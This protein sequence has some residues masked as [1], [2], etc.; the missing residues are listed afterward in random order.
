MPPEKA[1]HVTQTQETKAKA[2]VP[3]VLRQLQQPLGNLSVLSIELELIAIAILTKTSYPTRQTDTQA[4]LL[5]R[6]PSHLES[7]RWHYGFLQ[8]PQRTHLP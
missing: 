8:E 3:L 7:A 1:L 5:D 6:P 4:L 2:P